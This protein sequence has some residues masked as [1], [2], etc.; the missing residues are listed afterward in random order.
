MK[1]NV[2]LLGVAVVALSSCTQSEVL[3]VPASKKITFETFVEKNTRAVNDI[4]N[5]TALTNFKV[6]GYCV[7]CEVGA[8]PTFTEQTKEEVFNG[9]ETLE[10]D[11]DGKWGLENNPKYW[12]TNYSYRF[13]AYS[14]GNTT[15]PNVSYN[16]VTDKLTIP[17]YK[18]YDADGAQ[19]QGNEPKDLLAAIAGDKHS[20]NAGTA[21]NLQ[22]RHLLSKIT[23]YINDSSA[24]AVMQGT[25]AIISGRKTMGTCVCTYTTD[26]ADRYPKNIEWNSLTGDEDFDLGRIDINSKHSSTELTF[27]VI[28]QD[29]EILT[30]TMSWNETIN[31]DVHN[32]IVDEEFSLASGKTSVRADYEVNNQWVPGYHYQY[33]LVRGTDFGEIKFNVTGIDDWNSDLDRT[34]A[35]D[36]IDL[37]PVNP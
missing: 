1:Q 26:P 20:S 31:G 35:D 9:T 21:P 7:P 22:F 24:N 18:V 10:K 23:I 16:P 30:L 29:N 28:P 3:D 12:K 13:A 34:E 32:P 37:T 6:F 27:Y 36:D 19:T 15:H 5:P 2:W 8:T 33:T 4:V 11:D 25:K 17:D 14:N